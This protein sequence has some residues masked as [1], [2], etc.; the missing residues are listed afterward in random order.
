MTEL[1]GSLGLWG[2]VD[3]LE[4]MSVRLSSS[5][6]GK[7]AWLDEWISG[8]EQFHFMCN[9]H[10]SFQINRLVLALDC[11]RWKR[12]MHETTPIISY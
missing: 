1:W 10:L 4:S 9:R 3:D 5:H 8:F 2:A 12:A 7:D 11:R 6:A